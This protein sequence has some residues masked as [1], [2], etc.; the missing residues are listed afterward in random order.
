MFDLK[1]GASKADDAPVEEQ[2]PSQHSSSQSRKL[3]LA[4]TDVN[5]LDQKSAARK[6]AS[7]SQQQETTAEAQEEQKSAP[8]VVPNPAVEDTRTTIDEPSEAPRSKR[9]K[10]RSE[11]S[12]AV[13]IPNIIEQL[14]QQS[15]RAEAVDGPGSGRPIRRIR[16]SARQR[17]VSLSRVQSACI[18]DIQ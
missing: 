5:T 1:E 7:H 13:D 9:T 18:A 12:P 6:S 14:A 3:G 15:E 11:D 17:S 16:G 2:A 4:P 8:D 10:S